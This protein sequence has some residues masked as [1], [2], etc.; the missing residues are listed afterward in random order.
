MYGQCILDNRC[1]HTE[2]NMWEN[3]CALCL[4]TH[5]TKYLLW[6]SSGRGKP[7]YKVKQVETLRKYGTQQYSSQEA[8]GWADKPLAEDWTL[9]GACFRNSG[10]SLGLE[11]TALFLLS[12]DQ[13]PVPPSD[14]CLGN[15][16]KIQ[17]CW[18]GKRSTHTTTKSQP[19]N[20]LKLS[21]FLGISGY[22]IPCPKILL[23]A[24]GWSFWIM[25]DLWSCWPFP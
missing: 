2:L 11:S 6:F 5:D 3:T 21:T 4:S 12:V 24:S 25:L 23:I 1:Y 15:M 7:R 8:P 10:H 22:F 19:H 17:I 18:G 9:H 13:H 20:K 16:Q 14:K